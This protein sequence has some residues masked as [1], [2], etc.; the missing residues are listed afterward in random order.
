MSDVRELSGQVS[1]IGGIA[2]DKLDAARKCDSLEESRAVLLEV[3]EAIN[4]I[5]EAAALARPA[6]TQIGGD[7]CPSV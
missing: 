4:T 2:R 3:R 1:L 6:D 7:Q 5:L